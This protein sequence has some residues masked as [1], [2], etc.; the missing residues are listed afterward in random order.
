MD[1]LTSL[2]TKVHFSS[3]KYWGRGSNF[4][5]QNESFFFQNSRRITGS[6]F[7]EAQK[8]KIPRPKDQ[9]ERMAEQEYHFAPSHAKQSEC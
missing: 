6:I 9:D 5:R 2:F 8:T 3:F 1:I 7:I 4:I